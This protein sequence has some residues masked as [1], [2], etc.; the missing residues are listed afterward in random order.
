M[1][2]LLAI[3]LGPVQDF[4]AAARRT[5]DL[6]AGSQILQE[7]C[8]A[9]AQALHARRAELI[10]PSNPEANGANKILAR[11]G[12]DPEKLAEA[13]RH[14]AQQRLMALWQEHTKGFA[15]KIDLERARAQL[16][17]FLEFYAA[18]LPL[19]D[20]QYKEVRQ[21]VERLLAG[22]KALRDFA[23]IDQADAGVPKSPLDPSKAAVIQPKDWE[24]VSIATP[25]GYRP[26]RIKPTETLDA[27]SLLKRLYGAKQGGVV[28]DTRTMARRAWNPEA[29][30]EERY[31][32][33]DDHIQ[34]PQPY[35][36][37]LVADGDCMGALISQQEDPKAH[38]QLSATLD[39]FA[40]QA[41]KIVPSYRGFMVYSG[42]DDVLAFL[43]VNQA[44]ACAQK[45]A[46]AFSSQ[47]RG[48]LSAGVAI[49]HYRQPLSES[50]QAA[51]E[52]EKEAKKQGRNRLAVALHTRSGNPLMVVRPWAKLAWEPLVAA[53]QA[54]QV[55][56]GLA[57][58]L[59]ELAQV[60]PDDL[61]AEALQKEAQRIL[62]RKEGQ[63]IE[64]PSLGGPKDLLD[65]AHQLII[66]RFLAGLPSPKEEDYA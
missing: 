48:T 39:A 32:E 6:Y 7:L 4:I 47:V 5:A 51:R 34:E 1:N 23:P 42:G 27:L 2:H 56:R 20:G 58:E 46:E 59:A 66:A 15:H 37:V 26:L 43:P 21:E 64:I 29:R 65:F 55:S 3:S 8:K 63:G 62:K 10:F 36:A 54:G 22:R 60:W 61:D 25:E 57:Y 45:L 53:Y 24:G 49:V 38:R 11:V 35:F 33:D 14:A 19:P 30:P 31:G 52:A 18:W 16:E 50:L 41:R 13:A 44:V 40:Q 28:V 12:A 17:T 9:A